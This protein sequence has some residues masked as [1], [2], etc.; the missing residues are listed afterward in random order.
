MQD[1]PINTFSEFH[2]RCYDKFQI[3]T[4]FFKFE[5]PRDI[6]RKES[7]TQQSMQM[8]KEANLWRTDFSK[9][10]FKTTYLYILHLST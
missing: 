10:L 1:M 8:I 6:L 5:A 2:N 9:S 3:F 7:C 4:F